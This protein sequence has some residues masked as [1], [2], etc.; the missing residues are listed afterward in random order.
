MMT[1][2]YRHTTLALAAASTAATLAPLAAADDLGRVPLF[3]QEYVLRRFN[4]RAQVIMPDARRPGVNIPL[5]NVTGAVNVGPDRYL[6]STNTAHHS[7]MYS[8]KNYV[9]E[10]ELTRDGDGKPTGL[11]YRRTVLWNDP[12]FSGYDLDARGLTLNTSSVGLGAGGDLLVASGN[13]TLRGFALDTGQPLPWEGPINNGFSLSPP[14]TSTEDVAFVSARNGFFTAWRTPTAAVTVFSRSGAI[15]PAFY[16]GKNLDGVAYPGL[17]TGLTFC[18]A[19]PDYPR[20]FDDKPTLL[21]TLDERGPAIQAFTVDGRLIRHERLSPTLQPGAVTLP[22][23]GCTQLRIEAIATDAR[24]GDILLFLRGISSACSL[25]FVL[26]P[27][28]VPCLAD[29]NLDE[30]V[31]FFDYFDFISAFESASPQAD[32]NRDAFID[33]F[34]FYDF[35]SAFDMGC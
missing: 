1:H 35:T 14:N 9:I 13:N 4:Y 34:D 31:D 30:F 17:P 12:A 19:W 26:E 10:V 28:P 33:F 5:T 27:I 25:A 22:I 11:A 32:V 6:L 24:R 23:A 16:V 18:D 3:D 20:L 8:Y 2:H 7:P 15:G 29:F 21:V